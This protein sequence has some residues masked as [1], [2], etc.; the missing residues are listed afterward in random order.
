MVFIGASG[1]TDFNTRL[2]EQ[3]PANEKGNF[4]Y[5]G[6]AYDC[7]ALLGLAAEAAGSV[8]GPDLIAQVEAVSA[9]GTQCAKFAEC[10]ALVAQGQDIQYIG[11]SGPWNIV[12]ER[13]SGDPTVGRYAIA[14]ARG[15][16]LEAIGQ[17]DVDLSQV[18]G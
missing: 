11:E 14:L 2:N 13:G 7:V 1:G 18:G 15:G 5:G 3:L 8:S 9:G 17:Q 4:I 16:A 10:K 6:Q 12:R